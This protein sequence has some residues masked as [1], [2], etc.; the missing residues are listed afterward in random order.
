MIKI[1]T[2]K[3]WNENLKTKHNSCAKNGWYRYNTR[4]AL[5]VTNNQGTTY[6]Y[7]IYQAVL[8]IRHSSNNKFYLYDIQN[9]KKE[10]SNLLWTN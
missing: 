2:K 5:P 8:V 6:N 9:I 3:R 4:F 10:T 7:N 1:A